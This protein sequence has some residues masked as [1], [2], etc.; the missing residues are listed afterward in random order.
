[1]IGPDE[2]RNPEQGLALRQRV[3]ACVKHY[4]E[5]SPGCERCAFLARVAARILR[6]RGSNG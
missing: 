4:P 5:A 2:L 3:V 1:M 6:A